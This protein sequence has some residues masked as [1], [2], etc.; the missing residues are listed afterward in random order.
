MIGNKYYSKN[1]CIK[2]AEYIYNQTVLQPI[3]Y[4]S[5]TVTSAVPTQEMEKKMV[6]TIVI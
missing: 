3:L 6:K 4:Y 5:S 2:E 1:F